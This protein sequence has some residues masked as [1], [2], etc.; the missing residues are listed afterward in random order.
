MHITNRLIC[1][2]MLCL[3]FAEGADGQ[4][5]SSFPYSEDFESFTLCTPACATACTL[6]AGWVN[7]SADHTDWTAFS[8]A[9]ATSNTGPDADHTLGTSAGKYL[10]VEASGCL[11]S[12]AALLS[13][14]IDLSG[15]S[16]LSVDFW[17]HLYGN[18]LGR[19]HAD[20]STDGGVN[21]TN[22]VVPS[23]TQN[24][25]VWT[26]KTIP[27][28]AYLGDTVVLRLRGVTGNG[29]L[30]DI[31][32]DDFYFYVLQG[33]DAGVVS[34]DAPVNPLAAGLQAVRVTIHNFGIAGLD[35]VTIGWAVNGVPQTPYAWTGSLLSGQS[36]S[37]ILIGNY[38]FPQG[39]SVLK[40]WTANPNGGADND[41]SN[42]T[43]EV[44]LCTALSGT[45]TIGG[46]A[47]DF[48]G[49]NDAVT[50]LARCGVSGP[51]V[52]NVSPGSGPY[53]EPVSIP[54]ITGT[55]AVNTVTFNG[56]GDTI[57]AYGNASNRHVIR[58]DGARHIILDKLTIIG[59][60][61][62]YGW[63]IHL[64]N[65]A[66]S[67]II[68]NCTIDISANTSVLSGNSAGI[69]ATA[70]T[71]AVNVAG[72][73][74]SY[75]TIED[76]TIIG[77]YQGVR[78][79]GQASGSRNNRITGN[80]IRDFYSFGIFLGDCAN[81]LVSGNDISRAN[82]SLVGTF[83]GVNLDNR[84]IGTRVEKNRIH[85]T[86]DSAASLTALSQGI[87]FFGAD[88][89][90][91]NENIAV[92]NAIYNFNSNGTIYGIFNFNSDGAHCYHNTIS[93]DNTV[94]SG[95]TTRGF[96]QTGTASNIVFKN[97]IVTVRRSGSGAK[98]CLYFNDAASSIVSDYNVFFID[99]ASNHLGYWTADY[100][101]LADWQ[102]ADTSAFDANSVFADPLYN[103][104][105]AGNLA[106]T[107]AVVNNTG[108]SLGVSDDILGN[109]R[110]ATTP[111]AGA[112]EFSPPTQD[113]S[114]TWVSPVPPVSA[115]NKT[116]TV[117]LAN[118][119]SSLASIT[120]ANL[121]YTDGVAPVQ[122]LF[123]GLNIAP[124]S[125][126]N[127]SFTT[128]YNL[129]AFAA[130][131]AYINTIN[132]APDV[133]QTNDTAKQD[134][135][136]ALAGS[137]TINKTA[138]ASSTNFQSFGDAVD[139]LAT[140]G[141]SDTVT[142]NVVANSGPYFEQV[143][144]P[145]IPGAGASAQV[146]INGN[147]NVVNANP[148]SNNRSVVKLNGADYITLNELA[149]VGTDTTYGWGIHLTNQA[150]HNTIN[151]CTIDF[152]FPSGSPDD[153]AGIVASA[154]ATSLF[155]GGNNANYNTIAN[156][157]IFSEGWG[158][159]L[160]GTAVTPL[161]GNKITGVKFRDFYSAAIY[162]TYT[163]STEI[164]GNDI[165]RAI[166][167]DV[168][169]FQGI[170]LAAGCENTFIERNLIHN[171]HDA[172]ADKTGAV[173][174]IYF[175]NADA[176]P[177]KDNRVI[178]NVIH[179]INNNGVIY[180]IY[181]SGSDNARY[182]HN[183]IVLDDA[184][185]TT[186]DNTRGFYQETSAANIDFRNNIVYISRAGTGAKHCIYL[187]SSS[188]SLISDYNVL[189]MAAT[190]GTANYTGHFGT[191]DYASLSD[192]KTANGS[193]YD[194]RSS[195]YDPLFTDAAN[196]NYTPTN[197]FINNTGANVGVTV[198]I[199]LTPRNSAA[200]DPG[201]YEFN[202]A[203]V[204][205]DAAIAWVT[206]VPPVT[207]GQLTI[208][209]N[210][211]NLSTTPITDLT[212][213]YTDG[214]SVVTQSFNALSINSGNNQNLSFTTAY[215][216]TAAAFLRAY[217]QSV[218][219]ITDN[220]QANDTTVWQI[221]CTTLSGNYTINGNAPASATNF[222][223]F[224][225][226]VYALANC[227]I[228]ASVTID[229]IA[230]G[231]P[232]NEQV[233]IPAITGT[234]PLN[235]VTF[236][237]NFNTLSY[238][239]TSGAR[240][241]LMLNGAKHVVIEDLQ[242]VSTDTDYGFGVVFSNQADSNVI[243]GCTIDVS[244]ATSSLNSNSSGILFSASNTSTSA[245]GNNGSNNVI[246]GNT[247]IGGYYG[248]KINSFAAAGNKIINN[249][250]REFQT[251]G[252]HLQD[253]SGTEIYDN[254]IS[255]A[256]LVNVT[257][258]FNGIYLSSGNVKTRI[259]RNRIHNTHDN[260]SAV[261]LASYA[262]YFAN[263]DAPAGQENKVI[264]N[265][266]YNMNSKGAVY[267]IYNTSSNG[268]FY[269]HN[270]I[271]LNGSDTL[272]AQTAGFYQSSFADNVDFR[273]NL[274][275]VERT[276]S[277]N[278]YCLAFPTAT[279]NIISN[280]N[281]FYT[282]SD[283][284]HFIG[285]FG[286]SYY[287]T[288]PQW[289]A[290]S[291]NTFDQNSLF[292]NPLFAS[293]V[294]GNLTPLNSALNDKG[295]P[296]GVTEDINNTARSLT[297]PDIGAFEFTPSPFDA[298]VIDLTEPADLSCSGNAIGVSAVI[299]NFGFDTLT[300]SQVTAYIMGTSFS[301]TLSTTSTA[302]LA[303]G[304]TDTVQLGTISFI[305]G[306]SLTFTVVVK[307]AGDANASNDTAR[308]TIDINP[309]GTLPVLQ[310]YDDSVC[311]G[312]TTTISVIANPLLAYSWFDAAAGGN[313]V[314]T[315][316]SFT[317]PPLNSSTTYYVEAA[318]PFKYRAGP[319]DNSI[320]SGG[321]FLNVGGQGLLFTVYKNIT[322]DTVSVYPNDTGMV[323]VELS[324]ATNSI[325]YDVISVPVTTAGM[326]TKIPVRFSIAPG[327]YRLDANGTT[328]NGLYRNDMGAS[329][330]YSVPGVISITGNTNIPSNY[331]FFY[332]WKITAYDCPGPRAAVPVYVDTTAVPSAGF[333]Y[334]VGGT[335]LDVSFL[336]E[337]DRPINS[338]LWDFGDG[339]TATMSSI[340]HHYITDGS[341]TACLTVGNVCTQEDSCQSFTICGAFENS[342]TYS[343]FGQTVQFQFNGS[344]VPADYLW[345]FGDGA[346]S[347][348]AA[349][350]HTYSS[351]GTY[352]V[353]LFA[354]NLCGESDTISQ[355]IT[356][357]VTIHAA[358]TATQAAPNGLQFDFASISTGNPATLE[359]DFGDGTTGTGANVIHT[360][361]AHGRYDVSLIA[362]DA[363]GGA[364]TSTQ[365][366]ITCAAPVSDFT[367][368]VQ[369]DGF[370]VT[371]ENNSA[372]TGAIYF[373]NF[374][375]GFTSQLAEPSH[376]YS[377][378]GSY[379][380]TLIVA[381][382]CGQQDT[383]GQSVSILVGME[384][385]NDGIHLTVYPNPSDGELMVEYSLRGAGEVRLR[386]MNMIGEEV[387]GMRRHED[388]RN[389][390]SLQ[391]ISLNLIPKGIYFL[392]FRVQDGILVKKVV[393]E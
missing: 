280:Y 141:I 332:D 133:I 130:M 77:G 98:H 81:N 308:F 342:F 219:G 188:S 314:H 259:E 139:A 274:I 180:A 392:E 366:V 291:G 44:T 277:G 345:D 349:P 117:S 295:T 243:S 273:N 62:T 230:G 360:Y 351:A 11:N 6:S 229:V 161:R 250:I 72:N 65:S 66:D 247:I 34:I 182:Y 197:A 263:C 380:I 327:S 64:L 210:I 344:G 35:S 166:R 122:Q 240:Q 47:P 155:A 268:A 13:P 80:V 16:N 12:T 5:I 221:L 198:D 393:V 135:C 386:L 257:T 313:I 302:A 338:Y 202:A 343:A 353:T 177:G 379:T 326:K 140:C 371:T 199:N 236:S 119:A 110:S 179:S 37:S 275:S 57:L 388:L 9:T 29:S 252:V 168:G 283:A 271:S 357:C 260:A 107:S 369:G 340:T 355:S 356:V 325:V 41:S 234:S 181:N 384:T 56:N 261:T 300:S 167:T 82:R 38:N 178:N 362:T 312:M 253:A 187:G 8:G 254:D 301:D 126:Q 116:I 20:I 212:L 83:A 153:F 294:T 51:V 55:S 238:K 284:T 97:N 40:A 378:T 249:A 147:N 144:I 43:A 115:G 232:Y 214:N 193:A 75:L 217:I 78:I 227:G 121:T 164:T 2:A 279:S 361:N 276:G 192:W 269:Y 281:I 45:Y 169:L 223:S 113:A 114:L 264:N 309:S 162:L 89:A 36:S 79:H 375:D 32:L 39:A 127:L 290:V 134:L 358:F 335:G 266:I 246:T 211:S 87:V 186:A 318:S 125:A 171:T 52:I 185:A 215:N 95:G 244:A 71:V 315:G 278:K 96:F 307:T 262:I 323:Y 317:T 128:P 341:Y 69:V 111:D 231:G 354:D 233:T 150:D 103:N 331:F 17:Y 228:S 285:M 225:D 213:S 248:I 333:S 120:S 289:Q 311:A 4:I 292:A 70:S 157:L 84:T 195:A 60:D 330:P 201:A 293:A 142:L 136:P 267:G 149:I 146:I 76:N 389:S 59:A 235:T 305:S 163:D 158:I 224:T 86:H 316:D 237:G 143:V 339:N 105:A 336:A 58:L 203:P 282:P 152:V 265:A 306:G 319:A 173:Y 46:A 174:G 160:N 226:A 207:P 91:G 296:L 383:S 298:T 21:F 7:A 189:S 73:N 30:S 288:L 138:P 255:R 94:S 194:Q 54:H 239:P 299:S 220:N 218:N 74:A 26:K 154:S 368:T 61:P 372:G 104:A 376:A 137:F 310:A 170:T 172:A 287:M 90:A 132:G 183:T 22:D 346:T 129:T 191:S 370:T 385:L 206:P 14:P 196:D 100:R 109:P 377:A 145:E 321:N 151:N 53:L 123:S 93:L 101:T 15:V 304:H 24:S 352:T 106:P 190:G 329:Y 131:R 381:D 373:W 25:N 324:D 391:R 1:A 286:T 242:I 184:A 124:G 390:P 10:Y 363:C 200:P 23:W 48:T 320:G 159:R 334:T 175:N 50:T 297:A 19:L 322:L 208:T 222:R 303:N 68:R 31:G 92:N 328:T 347:T 272:S 42:D 382:E 33:T 67:N 28:D 256:N 85:N 205:L 118:S 108:D 387:K 18:D 49:F 367:A 364:D 241:V 99:T 3:P 209:V 245:A 365:T 148:T 165:S 337:D 27:L 374:G 251:Y 156:C 204:N 63:G 359:W 270:S 112:F 176:A 88:A 348:V 216:F 102:T 350:S 258:T